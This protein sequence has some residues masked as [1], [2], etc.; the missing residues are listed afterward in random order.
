MENEVS[1]LDIHYSV[2]YEGIRYC[3]SYYPHNSQENQW[4]ASNDS[5]FD[6]PDE[7]LKEIINLIREET[8]NGW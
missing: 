7:T 8:R 2:L 6:V 4:S 5:E 3:V 1:V